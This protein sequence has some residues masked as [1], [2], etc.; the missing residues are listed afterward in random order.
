MNGDDMP[1]VLTLANPVARHVPVVGLALAASSLAVAG[2]ALARSAAHHATTVKVT[3]GRP[4]EFGFVLSKR[5]VPVGKVTFT[6]RNGGTIGHDFKLC[7]SPKRGSADSCKGK[8]TKVIDPGASATLT[9]TFAAKGKYEYLCTVPTHAA[10]GMK[11][12]LT[13]D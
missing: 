13:V 8:G 6:V 5:T 12:D 10:A 3:A 1:R 11:G 7:S 9:V 2:P 4:T